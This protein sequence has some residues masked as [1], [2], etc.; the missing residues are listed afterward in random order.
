MNGIVICDERFRAMVLPNAPL[1]TLG[2][3]Y[4]WLEG[5]VWYAD[6]DCLYFSDVPN[7]RILRWSEDGGVSVFRKPSGFANG[8][9]RDRQGRLLG[10]RLPCARDPGST[11]IRHQ[12]GAK[13]YAYNA[14]PGSRQPV[15]NVVGEHN[16]RG[17]WIVLTDPHA[18]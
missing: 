5:P 15:E 18:T 8:H 11:N 9:A 7:D 6:H 1:E 14:K 10:I 4:R 17:E 13:D 2:E 12:Q 3:G 16:H